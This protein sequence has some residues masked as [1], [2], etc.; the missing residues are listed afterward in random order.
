MQTYT[1]YYNGNSSGDWDDSNNWFN[2]KGLHDG[3]PGAGDA[4][5]MFA[6]VNIAVDDVTVARLDAYSSTVLTG[7]LTVTGVL[8]AAI[9]VGGDVTV[10]TDDGSTFEGNNLT[11]K[12]LIDTELKTGTVKAGRSPRWASRARPFRPIA[13]AGSD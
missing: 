12:T 3:I 2:R 7:D 11:A 6:T 10:G 9:L 13:L 1:W 4:A 8:S 5:D